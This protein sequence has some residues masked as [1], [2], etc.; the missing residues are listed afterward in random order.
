V[1]SKTYAT[2]TT[3]SIKEIATAV[4]ET[5]ENRSNWGVLAINLAA[6]SEWRSVPT[7]SYAHGAF[8]VLEDEP[9]WSIR[10]MW[11][12]GTGYFAIDFIANE[13]EGG[14]E[15]AAIASYPMGAMGSPAPRIAKKVIS[16]L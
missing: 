3:R 8:G 2:R 1:G 9:D 12:A 4:K 6:R 7:A 15:V 16:M 13:F 11:E 14:W 10:F 5:C